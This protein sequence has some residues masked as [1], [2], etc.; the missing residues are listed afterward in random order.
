M[1]LH[2]AWECQ[3]CHAK[4]RVPVK[5]F[6]VHCMCGWTQMEPQPGLGD[7]V[8]AVLHKV[9]ITEDG[10]VEAKAAIGLKKT[11]NCGRR[12]RKLNEIGRKLGI[13]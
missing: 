13:G 5:G 1:T 12:Q 4:A 9:G 11:C 8:A 7:R 10:Y 6:P 2:I 3:V